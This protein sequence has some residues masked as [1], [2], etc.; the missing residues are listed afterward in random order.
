MFDESLSDFVAPPIDS[1]ELVGCAHK[2][3]IILFHSSYLKNEIPLFLF[4][5]PSLNYV[6]KGIA[7][8]VFEFDL[9]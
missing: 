3:T 2:T 7:F 6:V 4:C 1:P 9:T 5:S 8:S